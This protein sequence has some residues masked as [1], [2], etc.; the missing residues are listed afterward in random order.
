MA[1]ASSEAP[2][3]VFSYKDDLFAV[4]EYKKV[5][6]DFYHYLFKA[7][8]LVKGSFVIEETKLKKKAELRDVVMADATSEVI[9]KESIQSMIDK[10]KPEFPSHINA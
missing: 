9:T 4:Q 8:A 7:R 5:A 3:G 6:E 2:R 10:A 1:L